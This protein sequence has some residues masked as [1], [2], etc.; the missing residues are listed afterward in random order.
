MFVVVIYVAW[1]HGVMIAVF[2]IVVLLIVVMHDN[3]ICNL[4]LYA[5]AA[6]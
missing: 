6:L 2:V 5:P 1:A 4:S 3:R